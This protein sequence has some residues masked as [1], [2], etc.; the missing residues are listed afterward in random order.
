MYKVIKESYYGNFKN[1]KELYTVAGDIMNG[2][3][4]LNPDCDYI[5]ECETEEE[6][7]KK[8]KSYKWFVDVNDTQY[9]Y[10]ALTFYFYSIIKQT[11]N[12]T[13]NLGCWNFP[14]SAGEIVKQ[15]IGFSGIADYCYS[16]LIDELKSA[17]YSHLVYG[18]RESVYINT[19]GQV[20]TVEQGEPVHIGDSELVYSFNDHCDIMDNYDVQLPEY[21]TEE[22]NKIKREYSLEICNQAL[23]DDVFSDIIDQFI[24]S[25]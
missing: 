7:D 12:D 24:S 17:M 5:Y 2:C 4:D 10:K 21:G 18:N 3:A 23:Y 20:F 22:Y 1:V 9:N 6:A 8:A 25:N 14:K 13:E 15:A 11:E 19:E 16:D